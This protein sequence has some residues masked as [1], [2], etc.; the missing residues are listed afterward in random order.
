MEWLNGWSKSLLK[1]EIWSILEKVSGFNTVSLNKDLFSHIETDF[2]QENE[3]KALKNFGDFYATIT[4][5]TCV[6]W[7]LRDSN[8][9][10][11][12]SVARCFI[13]LN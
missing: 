1:L 9:H 4:P 12:S 10:I 8:P 2:I 3:I 7:F 5:L 11:F 6:L 13:Q